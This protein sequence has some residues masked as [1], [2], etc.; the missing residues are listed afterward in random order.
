M[1]SAVSAWVRRPFCAEFACSSLRR[2]SLGVRGKLSCYLKAE[3]PFIYG[4]ISGLVLHVSSSSIIQA[5]VLEEGDY[6]RS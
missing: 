4:L 6:N 5:G 2:F 1:V 3:S